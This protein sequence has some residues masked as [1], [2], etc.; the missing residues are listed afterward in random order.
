MTSPSANQYKYRMAANE[1]S[2]HTTIHPTLQQFLF[3]FFQIPNNTY[4]HPNLQL[5]CIHHILT[6]E[7][8]LHLS[9]R[10]KIC[11]EG[12]NRR[13]SGGGPHPPPKTKYPYKPKCTNSS[14]IHQI[15]IHPPQ[16]HFATAIFLVTAS[17]SDKLLPRLRKRPTGAPHFSGPTITNEKHLPRNKANGNFTPPG[18]PCD[19]TGYCPRE[20][21][22]YFPAHRAAPPPEN[23]T[24]PPP[25]CHKS[26]LGSL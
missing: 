25:A 7:I 23:N 2:H 19:A 20:G 3:L 6:S 8:D 11:T 24:T 26:A 9:P 5:Y 1:G 15:K 21:W 22:A 16:L 14:K 18:F 12:E 10:W 13:Y 4:P 17:S